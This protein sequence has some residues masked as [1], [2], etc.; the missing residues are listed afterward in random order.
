MSR[1]NE[2]KAS[3]DIDLATVL[4]DAKAFAARR[5]CAP[6][7]LPKACAAHRIFAVTIAGVP[8]YPAF[9]VD[10]RFDQKHLAAITKLLG[11]LSGGS[12]WQFFSGAKGSLGSI[13]PLQALLAGRY[14][15]VRVA[16]IGFSE[17]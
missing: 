17:R 16:A 7:A 13:T 15:E 11:G 4:L 10:S 14:K 5:G 1:T 3:P 8:H 12:K 2:L 9:Y 6:E